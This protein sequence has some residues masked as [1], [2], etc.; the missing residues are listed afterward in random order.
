MIINLPFSLIQRLNSGILS[1][2]Y[3]VLAVTSQ[4]GSSLFSNNVLLKNTST[5]RTTT[6]K[7]SMLQNV[8]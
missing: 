2:K 3:D 5:N 6:V 7:M 1:R 8:F 4:N